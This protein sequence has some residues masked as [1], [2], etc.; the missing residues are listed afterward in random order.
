MVAFCALPL[1]AVRLRTTFRLR[2]AFD[3]RDPAVR[4]V[5]RMGAWAAGLLAATQLL[6]LVELV[7][8]NQVKGGVV[9][10]QIGW[11][12]FLLPY[13]LFAQPVLT[14]LFPT[15]SRQAARGLDGAFAR[16]YQTSP[17]V[18]DRLG[19]PTGPAVDAPGAAQPFE[20]GLMLWRGD[21]HAVYALVGSPASGTVLQEFVGRL[22]FADTWAEGQPAGGGG[23]P[24]RGH[25][26]RSRVSSAAKAAAPGGPASS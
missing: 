14:A 15:L 16:L 1:L 17:G 6:I 3:R 13:A 8:A 4:G 21:Q 5:V 24:A 2:L 10:L 11:T 7:L 20:R 9:A 26:T 19:A 18:R 22:H 23:H 12:F 25:R